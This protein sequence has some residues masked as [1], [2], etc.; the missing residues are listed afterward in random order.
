[1]AT[2]GTQLGHITRASIGTDRDSISLSITL[3]AI[4]C[5]VAAQRQLAGRGETIFSRR[6]DVTDER[7]TS[8]FVSD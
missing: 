4:V 7:M 1:M 2:L 8:V 3:A 5:V 6:G